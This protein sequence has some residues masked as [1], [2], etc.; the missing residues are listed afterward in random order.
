MKVGILDYKNCSLY[1]IYNSVKVHNVGVTVVEN[2]NDLKNIDKLILPGVGATNQIMKFL[3]KKK[4]IDEIKEFSEMKKSIL[5]I[6]AGMQILSLNLFENEKCDGLGFFDANVVQMNKKTS[7]QSTNIG[8]YKVETSSSN[9]SY[10]FCHSFYLKFKEKENNFIK[11]YIKLNEKIPAII[12]KNNILGVQFHPEKS[13]R[14]GRDLI[15][16]FLKDE[17]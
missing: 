15:S 9:L 7:N 17:I 16:K 1:P 8:W 2:T 12:K 14:N 13:Q 10:Y 11:G 6:C 4:F 3:N 5:G